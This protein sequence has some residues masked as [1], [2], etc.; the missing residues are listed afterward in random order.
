MLCLE[1]ESSSRKR[2]A[3]AYARIL[4]VSSSFDPRGVAKV[5][6]R[7]DSL[8]KAIS[9]AISESGIKPGDIDYI[10]SCANSTVELDSMEVRVLKRIFGNKLPKIPVSSIKSVMGETFSAAGIL[11]VISCIGAMLHGVIPPTINYKKPDVNCQI[12]CVPNISRK[13]KID[14]A[15]VVSSGPGGYNSACILERT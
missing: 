3:R 1:S 2:K 15:L 6:P 5:Y 8:E 11:Q 4:S 10:S 14:V 9:D 12:D 13:N 7:G